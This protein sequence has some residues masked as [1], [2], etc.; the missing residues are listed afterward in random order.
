M[1]LSDMMMGSKVR[2]APSAESFLLLSEYNRDQLWDQEIDSAVPAV[3]QVSAKVRF[4]TGW[5]PTICTDAAVRGAGK[6]RQAT[7]NN[8]TVKG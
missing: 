3:W 1:P 2:V 4:R 6:R 5:E 7:P 8:R